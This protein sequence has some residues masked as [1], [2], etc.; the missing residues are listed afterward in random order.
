MFRYLSQEVD[1][2]ST[3]FPKLQ[4]TAH[5]YNEAIN[6]EPMK[7][8]SECKELGLDWIIYKITNKCGHETYWQWDIGG[9][10]ADKPLSG[11]AERLCDECTKEKHIAKSKEKSK[12]KKPHTRLTTT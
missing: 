8:R 3:N 2:L 1:H 10:W 12:N 4:V 7:W 9:G 6:M 5:R 11:M